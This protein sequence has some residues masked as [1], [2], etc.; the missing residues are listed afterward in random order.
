MF[1]LDDVIQNEKQYST[2]Q[3]HNLLFDVDDDLINNK[4]YKDRNSY[5]L[6]SGKHKGY[7]YYM[8]TLLYP[9]KAQFLIDNTVKNEIHKEFLQLCL[10]R[11][12]LNN[13]ILNRLDEK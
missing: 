3:L 4:Y 5:K 2:K 1:Y 7:S 8:M 10:K 9:S 11:M 12:K 13:I 6:L